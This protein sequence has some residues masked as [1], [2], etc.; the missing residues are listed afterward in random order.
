M[1][2]LV[3]GATG[4]LGRALMETSAWR[5]DAVLGASSRDADLRDASAVHTLVARVAPQWVILAAAWTDVDGCESDAAR[6]MAV[7]CEGALNVARA[8]KEAGSK[9][10]FVSTDYVFDGGAPAPT[11][12][13]EVDHAIAPINAYGRS[14][15]AAEAGL[16]EILPQVCIV[17]TSWL[18]GIGGKSFPETILRAAASGK[19]LSVVEDQ[20]GRPT[21]NRDLADIIA[22]L[23]RSNA[24]GTFQAANSGACSW[25]ELA[26][27]LVSAAQLAVTVSPTTSA[28]YP[29]PAA[30]PAY[31][32]LSLSSIRA[33]GIEPR[34]WQQA[35][36]AFV[37]ERN[38]ARGTPD[39]AVEKLAPASSG[40]IA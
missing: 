15:A 20:R 30:R 16:R 33:L 26:Q 23:V 11:A 13:Y 31:S 32:V 21:Y 14:K 24:S 3:L 6:A 2:I 40:R 10:L 8:A 28:A 9:L 5:C 37:A 36:A 22:K 34:P 25:F 35:V 12:P 27:E 19:N 1:R 4:L 18:Y 7:N 29:R 38:A 17:R 39:Q